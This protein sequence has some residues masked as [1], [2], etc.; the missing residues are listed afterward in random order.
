MIDSKASLNAYLKEDEIARWGEH[1]NIITKFKSFYMWRYTLILRKLEYVINC[2]LGVIGK[3]EKLYLQLRLQKLG[4]KLGWTIPPNVFGP[5]LCIV[6]PG[7]I[8]VNSNSKVGKNCRIHV[9]V[10][11]GT[12]QGSQKAPVL[13]NNI[14][15]GPGA[16]IFGDIQLADNIAIGANSVVNKSFTQKNITI[17]GVPAKKISDKGTT[18]GDKY[19]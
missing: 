5:G 16:K 7:T 8:V 2:K 9:C 14:Y 11:I 17:A 3:I 4:L 10:N 18:H 12:N 13:G 1:P 19:L 6:H 15:I